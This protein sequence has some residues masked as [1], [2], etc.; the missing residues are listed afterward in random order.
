V[1]LEQHERAFLRTL[2]LGD[3]PHVSHH[4][5]SPLRID[6]GLLKQPKLASTPCAAK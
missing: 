6:I 4:L 5:G 3:E 1:V 2:G